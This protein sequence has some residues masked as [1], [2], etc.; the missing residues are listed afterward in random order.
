MNTSYVAKSARRRSRRCWTRPGRSSGS[1]RSWFSQ[2]PRRKDPLPGL[3][4]RYHEAF[5]AAIVAGNEEFAAES[6]RGRLINVEDT[7]H[8]IQDDQP[9]VVEHAILDVLAG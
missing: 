3:P 8:Y 2:A 9:E 5:E 4:R 7:S 6:T 1:A